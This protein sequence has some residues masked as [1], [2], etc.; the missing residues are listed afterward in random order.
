M[1]VLNIPLRVA[2]RAA[3][4]RLSSESEECAKGPGL[5]QFFGGLGHLC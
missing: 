5:L 4:V 3:P 1:N 2:S